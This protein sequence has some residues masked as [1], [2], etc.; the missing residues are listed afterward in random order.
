MLTRQNYLS[1][2]GRTLPE[3]LDDRSEFNRLR[4]GS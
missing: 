2:K 3:L 4:T 1:V